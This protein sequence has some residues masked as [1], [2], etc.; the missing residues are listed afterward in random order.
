[1]PKS[2]NNSQ[3]TVNRVLKGFVGRLNVSGDIVM[4][5]PFDTRVLTFY[6]ISFR[7]IYTLKCF[8][9]TVYDTAQ[10]MTNL[11]LNSMGM[12]NIRLLEDEN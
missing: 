12:D 6:K 9:P 8:W 1:M 2:S 5:Y 7:E 11:S 4:F 3:S 10:L